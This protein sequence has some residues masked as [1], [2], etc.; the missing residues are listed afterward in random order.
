MLLNELMSVRVGV[1]VGGQGWGQGSGLGVRGWTGVDG[2]K[3]VMASCAGY[4]LHGSNV[5]VREMGLS[6]TL[7]VC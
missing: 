3:V 7:A 1:R 2:D 6:P 5:D 4:C